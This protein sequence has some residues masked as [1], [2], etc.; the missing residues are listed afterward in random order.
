VPVDTG[1]H[2]DYELNGLLYQQLGVDPP[3]HFLGVGSAP[4]PKQAAAVLERATAV[5]RTIRPD[6]V[7]VI[8]DTISTPGAGLAAAQLHLPLVHVEAGLRAEE[9]TMLEEI[10]RRPWIT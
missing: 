9:P 8:G 4:A 10:S 7:V 6:G 2:Y 5:Y 3:E 1:Q